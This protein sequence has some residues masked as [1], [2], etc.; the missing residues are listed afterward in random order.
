MERPGQI[1]SD[2]F[3][4]CIHSVQINGRHLNL[5]KPIKSYGVEPAC[6]RSSRF[7]VCSEDRSAPVMT[8]ESAS[9][10]ITTM[11]IISNTTTTTTT[12]DQNRRHTASAVC[13]LGATGCYDQWKRTVCFCSGNPT[14]SAPNCE[15]ALEPVTLNDGS[16][17]E[18]KISE[19]HRRVNLLESIY[20]GSTIWRKWSE[21]QQNHRQDATVSNEHHYR[22]KR[23]ILST[24]TTSSSLEDSNGGP[25]FG[26]KK[27]M[28]L[29]FRTVHSSGLLL[30][31]ATN[32]DFTS[33]EVS[34]DEFLVFDSNLFKVEYKEEKKLFCCCSI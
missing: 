13:G 1:L 9:D 24:S 28:T 8:A 20:R 29:M 23:S 33:V 32:K 14:Y 22:S 30:Y 3:V 19:K 5:S 25:K 4:G 27:F 16:F 17:V 34:N 7:S 12:T 31:S 11:S 18:F 21:R 26:F 2:D 6:N 15:S 10:T